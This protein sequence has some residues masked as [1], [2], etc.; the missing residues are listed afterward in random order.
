MSRPQFHSID[1]FIL[2]HAWL[3]LR[4]KH[5]TTGR[6]NQ[7]TIRNVRRNDRRRSPRKGTARRPLDNTPFVVLEYVCLFVK[8][9]WQHYV[10]VGLD[11]S[12]KGNTRTIA[13]AHFL[14][15]CLVDASFPR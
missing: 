3:S 14:S 9:L 7:K 15:R 1:L 4:D 5:M 10:Q 2:R 8:N 11:V 6:V 12:S 13:C